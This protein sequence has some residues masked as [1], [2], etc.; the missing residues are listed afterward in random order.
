MVNEKTRRMVHAVCYLLAAVV[1]ILMYVT[2]Q[3]TVGLIGG[4]VCAA[5]AVK[6]YSDYKY[7]KRREEEETD[8]AE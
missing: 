4:I 3:T 7:L 2:K 8:A 1:L 5:L 6:Y